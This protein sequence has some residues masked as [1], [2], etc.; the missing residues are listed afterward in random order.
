MTKYLMRTT[1]EMKVY[2]RK[3]WYIDSNIVRDMFINAENI[4]SAMEIYRERVQESAYIEISNNAMKTKSPMYCGDGENMR[5]CGYV[6]TAST[7]FEDRDNYKY[8]KQ[9][10]ELWI[11]IYEIND[12]D[13]ED[14]A[15]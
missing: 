15:A 11:S 2:N 7:D 3:K 1:A 5:Q 14:S 6:I 12:L 13:F 8:S 10:I 9:Y 4:K